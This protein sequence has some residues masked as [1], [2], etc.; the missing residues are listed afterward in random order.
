MNVQESHENN[1]LNN[2]LVTFHTRVNILCAFKKQA[3]PQLQQTIKVHQ[4]W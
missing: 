4:N 1:V 3:S 2:T